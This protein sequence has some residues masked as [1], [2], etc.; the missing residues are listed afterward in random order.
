MKAY[1]KLLFTF[2]IVALLFN[3]VHAQDITTVEAKSS[4]I[5][6]NLDLEVVASVFGEAKDLED[7]EKR[8]NDPE[9]QISNLDLNE[10][11][12]VDYLRVV[13]NSKNDTHV[14]TI[15]AVIGKD[16]YQDVAVIDVEKDDKGETTVQVVGDVYMYGPDYIITPVYVHPPVIW[17][18][19][20]GTLY[21][22]WNSPY[23]WGYYPS[24]YRPWRP[25][26]VATYRSN[27]NVNINVNNTYNRTTI[28]HSKTSIDLQK[29]SRKNDFGSRN[30]DKS[31]KNRKT[32]SR[33]KMS[34]K[35][36]K[37]TGRKVQSDWKKGNKRVKTNPPARSKVKAKRTKRRGGL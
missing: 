26:P 9:I 5:S 36:P 12:E 2:G 8:L 13:E 29:K 34:S 23:Y 4:D 20:W 3:S 37:A 11:E 30:P 22:P 35:T 1:R 10:D 16:Q 15:Q 24:F 31:H 6:E 7:F 28:R 25:Y 19:F 27:V 18:W 33:V 14:V 17:V 21:R 32:T